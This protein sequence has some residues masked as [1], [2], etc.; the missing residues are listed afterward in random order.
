MNK[1]QHKLSEQNLTK[2]AVGIKE[3]K[4]I[5]V[6]SPYTN[7]DRKIVETNVAIS[8]NAVEELWR[9]GFI[10][11]MALGSHYYE[12]NHYSHSHED[13]MDFDIAW[14]SKCDALLRLPGN[15][16]GADKEV[17]FAT[18]HGIPVFY[19][20]DTLLE[21]FIVNGSVTDTREIID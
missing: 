19:S 9:A 17:T 5:Y 20:I 16:K 3:K 18:E 21:H 11:F 14:L 2:T 15:S 13:W 1:T 7:V 4:H 12:L 8:M 6:A 10:P